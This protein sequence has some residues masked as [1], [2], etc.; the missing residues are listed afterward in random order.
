[1]PDRL[2]GLREDVVR[3]AVARVYERAVADRIGSLQ[4]R[5]DDADERWPALDAE[6]LRRDA[7]PR[8][9]L[10]DHLG[11][12]GRPDDAGVEPAAHVEP[13]DNDRPLELPRIDG[14]VHEQACLVRGGRARGD[15]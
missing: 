11:V 2:P 6:L 3:E 5:V 9:P 1:M 4:R 15:V 13:L 7:D 8:N 10:A 12:R 14:P